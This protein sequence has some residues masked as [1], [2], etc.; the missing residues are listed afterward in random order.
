MIIIYYIYNTTE[1]VIKLVVDGSLLYRY[2]VFIGGT[3][4]TA[5]QQS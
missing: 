1:K 5:M 3:S 2:P 4:I